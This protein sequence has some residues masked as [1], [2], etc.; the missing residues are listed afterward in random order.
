MKDKGVLISKNGIKLA[1]II[2]VLNIALGAT[3]YFEITDN[4]EMIPVRGLSMTHN[5]PRFGVIDQADTVLV[6]P[7][8]SNESI[9]TYFKCLKTGKTSCGYPGDVIVF[10]ADGGESVRIVHRVL[11]YLVFNLSVVSLYE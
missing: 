6:T 1:I 8:S 10:K 3:M 11:F 9:D 2:L 7:Y 4:E 5:G